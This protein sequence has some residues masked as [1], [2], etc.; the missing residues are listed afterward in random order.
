MATDLLELSDD[1]GRGHTTVTSFWGGDRRGVMIQLTVG[2]HR[3]CSWN[4]FSI[5]G[6]E[7]LHKTLGDWIARYRTN[8][9]SGT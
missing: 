5:R 9:P 7:E 2:D 8:A 4:S 3:G 1:E 6:V